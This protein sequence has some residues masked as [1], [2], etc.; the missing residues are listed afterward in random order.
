MHQLISAARPP[1]PPSPLVL[2]DRLI[3]LAQDADRAGLT[4][5][6]AHLV[7]LIDELFEERHPNA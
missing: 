4:D 2:C 7:G 3:S 1:P 6:A 5:T